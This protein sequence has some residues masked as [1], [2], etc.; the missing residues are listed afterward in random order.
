MPTRICSSTLPTSAVRRFDL[1]LHRVI[2]GVGLDLHQLLLVLAEPLLGAREILVERLAMGL[3]VGDGLLGGGD[4]VARGRELGVERRNLAGRVSNAFPRC[5]GPG[6]DVLQ[7]NEELEIRK[8]RGSEWAHLDSNQ[9][10][11]DYEP[12]ALTAELWAPGRL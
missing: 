4:G 12:A 5:R 8:H 6:F 10:P 2:L 9:G 7:A 3:V 11:T 1:M